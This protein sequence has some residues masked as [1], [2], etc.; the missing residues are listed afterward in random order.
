ML[1]RRQPAV[2]YLPHYPPDFFMT[3][4]YLPILLIIGISLSLQAQVVN[5]KPA[6]VGPAKVTLTMPNAQ[7]TEVIEFY[8]DLT[9]KRVIRD[10]KVEDATIS[11]ET[12]GELTKEEAVDFMEKTLLLAGYSFVPSGGNMVKLLATEQAR[13][14]STEGVPMVLKESDLPPG[15][16]VVSHILQLQYLS[17][18]D[19]AQAFIQIIPP[20]PYGKVAAVP[21]TRSLV[22]TENSSTIRAY[23]DLA[24]QVDLPPSETRHKTIHLTRADATEVA[25]QLSALLGLSATGSG[26][27]QGGTTPPTPRSQTTNNAAMQNTGAGNP[28][29]NAAREAAQVASYTSVPGTTEAS[30]PKIQAIARTNSLLIVAR[31]LDIEYIEKLVAELDAESPT[32]AI[33]SRQLH[34]IDLTTFINIAGKALLRNQ[35]DAAGALN[36][37]TN[38]NSTANTT[39]QNSSGTNG[40]GSSM[41]GSGNSGLNSGGT[42]GGRSLSGGGSSSLGFGNRSTTSGQLDITRKAESVL[43]GR[44]LVI[45]DPASS[46]Y[47]ASGPP[48][49]LK[50]LNDLAEELDVRPR[51][52]FLSVIIGEF[53][54]GNDMNFGLDWVNTLQKVGD[55]NLIGGILNTQGT[56]FANLSELGTVEDFVP[57]LSGLTLYG[58][59]GD[60]LNVFLQALET[61]NRFKVM[62]KPTV[63][64]LNH[65]QASIFIGQEI[66]IAGETLSTTDSTTSS[67]TSIRSTTQYVPVRLQ[68]NITPHIYN[69]REVMLE[70][71]Q[72]NND[73][74]GYTTISGNQVPNLSTQ[75]LQ[76]ILI[77]PDSTTAMLGGL[78]TERDSKNKT[79]LPFLIRVP[80]LKHLFGS[81]NRTK[82]RRELIIFV[83]PRILP[84]TDTHLDSQIK[85]GRQATSYEVTE[86]FAPPAKKVESPLLPPMPRWSEDT[87]YKVPKAEAVPDEKGSSKRAPTASWKKN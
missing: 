37:Q 16:Q 83:Q 85:W 10:P 54:L 40:F 74:S 59:I 38:N 61:S 17:A 13:M 48:D 49:E 26:S 41:N 39:S 36:L 32:K 78:I 42:L 58:Q 1:H 4:V 63:T 80:I 71:Q 64:T 14:P 84:D 18:E 68:L 21:N 2:D 53:T 19:A 62:Q 31:P 46:K 29:Q 65:Q 11:I 69:D 34:Y 87:E 24:R 5:P 23:L 30:P 50:M 66:A 9:G 47:F 56:A 52:I 7:L 51:Q 28:Q 45:V 55:N 77:V 72:E 73:I 8:Q 86:R 76:N 43:I 6:T 60:N 27:G 25:E 67:G 81:T 75:G 57:A 70:F 35:P 12:N 15:D 44:T 79:G 33:T 22:I 3:K 82:E 20:H